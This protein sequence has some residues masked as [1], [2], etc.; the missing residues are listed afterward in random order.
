[1]R[2]LYRRH[3]H[4][5]IPKALGLFGEAAIKLST[6]DP[7]GDL[8]EEA[9]EPLTLLAA[10]HSAG[11]AWGYPFDVQTRWSFYSA[12]SPNVVVTAFAGGALAKGAE[13]FGVHHFAV[14]STQAAQ[15]V[16]SKCFNSSLGAF[17]YHEH[18]DTVIHNANLLG[19]RLVWNQLGSDPCARDAVKRSVER[20]LAAQASDGTWA[21]GEGPGL[22]WNDSF[23]TGFVLSALV[24]LSDVDAA[25]SDAVARGATAYADAFFGARGEAQLWPNKQFPEDAHAAGTGLST[26]AKLNNLTLVDPEL[27][28]RVA[29]RVVTSTVT[30]AHAIWR[31]NR[32]TKSHIPYIRWCDAHV[33]CG[34]ADAAVALA[35]SGAD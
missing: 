14:R 28:A 34:I 17:S 9:H 23:H 18:S 25:V 2:R 29:N 21:Y 35:S 13:A 7:D 30:D 5:R 1:M 8:R 32:W 27:L 10:D 16:L 24:E 11:D 12:Y 20:T 31:R 4:A 26:L 33:A 6:I 22:E 19:A 15:W 3:Q